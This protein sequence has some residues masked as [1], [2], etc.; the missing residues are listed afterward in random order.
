MK[1]HKNMGQRL[2]GLEV[3]DQLEFGR[4]LLADLQTVY[5]RLWQVPSSN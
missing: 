2:C 4:R 1:R 3:D 5:E